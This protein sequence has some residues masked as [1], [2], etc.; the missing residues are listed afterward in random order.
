MADMFRYT[1]A[2]VCGV[3]ASLP[4]AAL[5]LEADALIVDLELARKQHKEYIDVLEKVR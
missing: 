2:I 1:K 5:R 4:E 3:P